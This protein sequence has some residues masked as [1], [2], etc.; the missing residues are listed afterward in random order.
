MKNYLRDKATEGAEFTRPGL[1]SNMLGRSNE[2][3]VSNSD[4]GTKNSV[5]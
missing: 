2:K 4:T 3:Q 1:L 5:N